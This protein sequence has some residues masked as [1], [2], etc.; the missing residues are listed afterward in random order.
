MGTIDPKRVL[1]P[2]SL[3]TGLSL[4]GDTALYTVLPTNAAVAGVAIASVGVLLSVNRFIR[5]FLN[6][7]IGLLA[8][9]WPRR[10]VFVPA[11]FLGAIST[12]LYAMTVGFWPLLF[13][14]L[15]WGVAW[16]GIW[17]SG[18]AIILDIT[19]DHDRGRWIGRYHFAFFFG[20]ASGA[21]LGGILTDWLG[22]RGAM[23]VAASLTLGGALVALLMLP[24]TGHLRSTRTLGSVDDSEQQPETNSDWGQLASVSALFGVNRLVIAGVWAYSSQ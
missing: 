8:D 6:T 14:R 22:Y 2:V 15:L 5:L 24:E 23:T 12:G 20:A 21:I 16:A 3:A 13:G 7:P 4:L 10:R 9:R 19:K 17:V 11:V 1:V 18:N